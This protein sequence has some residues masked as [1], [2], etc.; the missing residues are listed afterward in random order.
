[1]TKAFESKC[2][3]KVVPITEFVKS[4]SDCWSPQNWLLYKCPRCGKQAHLNIQGEVVRFGILD[5]APGPCF[6]P[7]YSQRIPELKFVATSKHAYISF[8]SVKN[9][10]NV[11]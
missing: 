2:C 7:E 3:S 9:K 5:G 1:M 4:I 6:I 10:V 11:R 8:G